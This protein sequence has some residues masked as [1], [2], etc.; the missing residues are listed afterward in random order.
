MSSQI[1]CVGSAGKQEL[2]ENMLKCLQ[3]QRAQEEK[4]A[5]DCENLRRELKNNKQG[6]QPTLFQAAFAVFMKPTTS[7]LAKIQQQPP[8]VTNHV[9]EVRRSS[10]ID[11]EGA[12]SL[13]SGGSYMAL[14]ATQAIGTPARTTSV[15]RQPVQSIDDGSMSNQGSSVKQLLALGAITISTALLVAYTYNY[16]FPPKE[17]QAPQLAFEDLDE[18]EETDKLEI[19]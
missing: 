18:F 6:G 11:L 12:A 14:Q 13:L 15:H 16:F 4:M 17:E 8:I 7:D 19:A 1:F 10:A 5:F 3:E 9:E 2:S